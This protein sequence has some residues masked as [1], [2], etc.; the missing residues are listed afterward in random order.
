M[1]KWLLN[2][3][4]TTGGC[5]YAPHRNVGAGPRACPGPVRNRRPCACPGPALVPN[6]IQ[7][8][9]DRVPPT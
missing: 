7:D 8:A 9:G 1:P 3:R 4:A 5:P 6:F 2:T